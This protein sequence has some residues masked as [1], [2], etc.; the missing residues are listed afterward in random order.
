MLEGRPESGKNIEP[1]G[2]AGCSSKASSGSQ[3]PEPWS[4]I[5]LRTDFDGV[6]VFVAQE[7]WEKSKAQ[8]EEIIC[9]VDSNS[10]HLLHKRLEQVK[11][12]LQYMTHTYSGMT[13]YIIGLHLTINGWRDNHLDTGCHK[14]PTSK[15][16]ESLTNLGNGGISEEMVHMAS[17]FGTTKEALGLTASYLE[18][19]K[20]VSAAPLYPI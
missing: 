16:K 11:G 14:R 17:A 2:A 10:D 3:A 8:V 6:I 7:K 9:V 18:P 12:C 4:G 20:F 1:S 19:P 13:P 5:I 15:T